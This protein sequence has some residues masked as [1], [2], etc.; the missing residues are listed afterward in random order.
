[1][2]QLKTVGAYNISGDSKVLLRSTALLTSREIGKV[3]AA[4]ILGALVIAWLLDLWNFWLMLGYAGF[5]AP[6]AHFCFAGTRTLAFPLFLP[7]IF[8]F[9]HIVSSAYCYSHP[10]A[11]SKSQAIFLNADTYFTMAALTT[12][13]MYLCLLVPVRKVRPIFKWH[14]DE[15]TSSHMESAQYEKVLLTTFWIAITVG[16][17]QDV[18]SRIIPGSAFVWILV[19][20]LSYVSIV[21]L[22]VIRSKRFMRLLLIAAIFALQDSL[23]STLFHSFIFFSVMVCSVIVFSG[24][25]WPPKK[26]AM[27]LA[28]A[29][30]CILVLQT[31]KPGYRHLMVSSRLGGIEKAFALGQRF[32]DTLSN[33]T[34]II[35]EKNLNHVMDRFDQSQ[36]VSLVMTHVPQFEP[37]AGGETITTALYSAFV[38]RFFDP[39]KYTAGGSVFF[40]RFTGY[41]VARGTSANLGQLAEFYANFGVTGAVVACG[42]YAFILG[43]IWRTFHNRA[44]ENPIWW[45][46]FP[47]ITLHLI[48]TED[49]LGELFTYTVKAA[50]V[51]FFVIKF[52]PEWKGVLGVKLR[53]FWK[54]QRHAL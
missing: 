10:S 23:T 50:I 16:L 19:T 48:K 13:C 47:Y 30:L 14:K 3:I 21:A 43:F 53:L 29:A 28:I 33:P 15:Y 51:A 35:S 4:S 52:V 44:M 1:M 49:G 31:I 8:S 38:P 17:F 22:G 24:K 42:V 37:Y 54:R 34:F 12:W 27:A 18:L 32:F 5:V 7:A 25:R 20:K 9:Q 11:M 41:R 40:E 26:M 45:A 39:E 6:L 46:W 2:L 36:V